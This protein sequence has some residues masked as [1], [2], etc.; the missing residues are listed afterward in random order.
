[1][2]QY[3]FTPYTDKNVS[4]QEAKQY[5]DPQQRLAVIIMAVAAV[6]VILLIMAPAMFRSTGQFSAGWFIV[7]PIA[8]FLAVVGVIWWGMINDARR[9]VRMS[10]FATTNGLEF[11]YN[12]VDPNYHGI[13]FNF[14]S[15]RKIAECLR[16]HDGVELGRYY[17]ETGSG[18]SRRSYNLGYAR[19]RLTRNLPNIVLDSKKNNFLGI[20]NLPS[21]FS[22]DQ[23]LQLEGNFNDYYTLYAP[24]EYERDVFYIFTPDVMQAFIDT[25]KS[26][27]VEIVDNELYI[28]AEK[29]SDLSKPDNF[30]QLMH[31]VDI[32]G[33]KVEKSS[34]RYTDERVGNFSKNIVAR[35]GQ[36]LRTSVSI[37]TVIIIIYF[38][39]NIV[40][41]FLPIFNGDR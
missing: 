3:N 16:T 19:F 34:D 37:V 10:R 29:M 11:G 5:I 15:D 18:R 13:Y 35:P 4:Y 28:Y 30:K 38:V 17:Y 23:K 32:L 22:R 26:I 9:K 12:I 25:Q 1:M 24:K 2:K 39:F 6:P 33:D 21:T 40:M 14:G 7:V 41:N 20:T 31:I 36:R 27:D 8:I